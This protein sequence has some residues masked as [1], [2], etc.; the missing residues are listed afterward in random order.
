MSVRPPQSSPPQSSPSQAPSSPA[1]AKAGA[2]TSSKVRFDSADPFQ[3]NLRKRVERYFRMTGL[4]ERDLPSMYLK[5]AC[6][7]AWAI[8]SYVLLVF[9]ATAWWQAIPL[10]IS[11]GLATAAIGFNVQH[12]GGHNAYSRRTW[13]NKI[14]AFTMD[15]VG[16]SSFVWNRKHN[17][18]HH[19][20]TNICGVDDDIEVGALG[21]LAPHQRHLPFHRAQHIYLWI[22]YAFLP[23][24]WQW[25]DDFNQI[26][27]GKIGTQP[28][29][30]P[31][32]W[33]LVFFIL[34]K[35]FFFGYALVL[36]MFF[37]PWY[38]VLGCYAV[39]CFAQGVVLSV[40]FQMAHVVEEADFPVPDADTERLPHSWAVH[41]ILTTVDFGRSNKLLSWYV[42]G[43]NFQVEHHLFPR[44]C[45]LHYPKISR[46]VEHYCDRVGVPY[47]AN[48][49][50]VSAIRSHYRWV[51][52]MGQPV[53]AA[54]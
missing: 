18:I 21:R 1:R 46:L 4:R 50:L 13:V 53:R 36:P 42:G 41:Q 35:I 16:G 51:K 6:V 8:A 20:F 2:G 11:I 48:K 34:G 27:R 45:H 30:R 22:L 32:G 37:H 10:A 19:T 47:R 9:V 40:V 23:M 29:K 24:K 28:M 52:R 26:A 14:M 38:A 3:R 7:F 44:I 5:T 33:P 12:D 15:M 17:A 43:L 25:F 54:G 49:T 39:A 31:T